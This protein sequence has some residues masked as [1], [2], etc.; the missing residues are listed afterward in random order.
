MSWSLI[1][2]LVDSLQNTIGGS[3]DNSKLKTLRLQTLLTHKK[4]TN[5]SLYHELAIQNKSGTLSYFYD[6]VLFLAKTEGVYT[7]PTS[8]EGN[9]KIGIGFKMNDPLAKAIFKKLYLDYDKIL[10]GEKEISL[11]QAGFLLNES[12]LKANEKLKKFLGSEDLIDKLP[13]PVKIGLNSMA[14]NL[15]EKSLTGFVKLKTAL[16]NNDFKAAT[17]ELKDS[18]WNTQQNNKVEVISS[19]FSLAS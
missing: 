12:L 11:L 4:T 14:L 9:L 2:S 7:T 16:I 5:D 15:S 1:P 13:N 19:L 18:K 10:N 3:L 17:S 6:L 8:I